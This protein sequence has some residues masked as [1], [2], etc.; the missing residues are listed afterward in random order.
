MSSLTGVRCVVPVSPSRQPREKA[1][2]H[3]DED[4]V[5]WATVEVLA[6]QRALAL[7]ETTHDGVARF[8]LLVVF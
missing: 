8:G 5:G 6:T 4:D 1:L 3:N 7:P 2:T